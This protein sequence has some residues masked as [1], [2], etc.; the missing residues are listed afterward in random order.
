MAL[1]VEILFGVYLGLLTG[2]LPAVV[3]WALAFLVRYFTGVSVPGLAVV[4][5][6]LAIAGLNGG[7][8]GL[9]EDTVRNSPR[10]VTATLVVLMMSLYA[11]SQGDRMGAAFPRRL[12]WRSLRERTLSADAVEWV[13]TRGEVRV[14]P[15]GEVADLEGYPPLPPELRAELRDGEWTFPADL[16]LGEIEARLAD[17]LRSEHDLAAVTATVD[18][19]GRATIAAAPPSGSLSRRVTAGK[20]AVSVEALLPTGLARGDEVT[21]RTPAFAVEGTVVSARTTGGAG[22]APAGGGGPT[23]PGAGGDDGVE[24]PAGGPPATDGGEP[25]S[26]GD[27]PPPAQPAAPTTDGGEGRVTVA[28]EPAD[29]ERLLGVDRARVTVRSRGSRREYELVSLLRQAGKRFRKLTVREGGALDGTT[30]GEAAIDEEYGV[31]I[32]G[33][34]HAPREG[35]PAWVVAPGGGEALSAGDELFAVGPTDALDR[36]REVAA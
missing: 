17:R 2:I 13:G 23:A 26:A 16:P 3:A 7:L 8:L 30:I 9:L 1:P 14:E 25:D 11:H 35:R 15:V 32:L 27:G 19:A 33:V 31:K 21:V 34:R 6:G 10:L 5:L 28:V 36:L 18:E 4:V 22:P 24:D 20:R 29:A 12:T